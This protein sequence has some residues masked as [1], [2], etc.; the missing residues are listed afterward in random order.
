MKGLLIKD[1]LIMR[2]QISSILLIIGI[3][4]MMSLY[5]ESSAVVAYLM[6]LGAMMA[7]STMAYDEHENGY[8]Y[9]FTLPT[10][11]KE[12]VMEKY[13][14][15]AIW[16]ACAMVIGS[17]GS[18]LIMVFK[19]QID[20]S[21]ILAAMIVM[22]GTISLLVSV[23]IPARLKYGSEKS[24]II[25]YIFFGIVAGIGLFLAKF[26]SKETAAMIENFVNSNSTIISVIMILATILMIIISYLI[27]VRIMQK[28]EF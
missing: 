5:M 13:L 24:K 26:I 8:R 21:E 1:F 10:T 2:N 23:T 14:F 6:M 27:S 28:K 25:I 18:Y 20:M 7:L 22:L 11:R 12:Y 17:I 9:M 3:G 16:I 15:C 4:M 19:K